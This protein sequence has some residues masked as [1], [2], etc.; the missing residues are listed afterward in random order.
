MSWNRRIPSKVRYSGMRFLPINDFP[1]ISL[2]RFTFRPTGLRTKAVCTALVILIS[3]FYND[4]AAAANDDD[5]GGQGR[6]NH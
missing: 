5:G 1:L 6:I 4:A 2:F 3:F